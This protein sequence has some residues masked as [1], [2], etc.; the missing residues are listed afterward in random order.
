MPDDS[1]Y[2]TKSSFLGKKENTRVSGA[3]VDCLVVVVVWLGFVC[4]FF[5]CFVLGGLVVLVFFFFMMKT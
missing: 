5:C 4:G 2:F 1:L 3:G